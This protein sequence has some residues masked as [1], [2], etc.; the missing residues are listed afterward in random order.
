[1]KICKIIAILG[2]FLFLANCG[3]EDEKQFHLISGSENKNLEPIVT[4][5]CDAH[6]WAC[7]FSYKGSVDIRLGLSDS[8]FPY[9]AVWPAHSMW[10][11]LGDHSRRVRHAKSIFTSPVVFGLRKTVAEEL[12]LDA[13][14][15]VPITQL[16]SLV[17]EQK[18]KFVMTSATQ[19]NSGFVGLVGFA[20]ALQNN[21]K[22][23]SLETLDQG[24]IREDIRS[25]LQGVTRSSGSSGWLKEMFVQAAQDKTPFDAMVNYEA[26][27][28]EANQTL[29]ASGLEPMVILYLADGTGF[30]DS[31]LGFVK[32]DLD[33]QE[34]REAFFLGLQN[35]LLAEETQKTLLHLGRRTGFGSVIPNPPSD[36]FRED[37]GAV[38]SRPLPAIRFPT[39]A[40]VDRL[41]S[42]YQMDLRKPTLLGM[43]LDFSGSM[44]GAGHAQLVGAAETIFD[45]QNAAKLLIQPHPDD[46]YVL[47]PFSSF[48]HEPA[49]YKPGS[50]IESHAGDFNTV[51]DYLRAI[52]PEGGTDIYSCVADMMALLQ[53]TEA[54]QK[55]SHLVGIMLQSDGVSDG[56]LETIDMAKNRLGISIPV[57]ALLFGD[58]EK[59]QMALISETTGGRLFDGRQQLGAA[60]RK[61]RGYQ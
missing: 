42:D 49:F 46:L 3:G 8:H 10:I 20:T 13:G 33:D 34:E 2:V 59:G 23:L 16:I 5:Y 55:N 18:L 47:M 38:V 1:M 45:P 53:Q 27:I 29:E 11:E 52:T 6:G 60:F 61:A 15:L 19:S 51:A 43:C 37:W 30:A 28:L 22:P 14:A 26:L 35:H 32:R 17:S 7:H 50:V 21:Q 41:L 39:A 36:V 57:H 40:V 56:G 25:L 44:E 24:A 4:E 31:P 9:D 12:G 48:S 54:F 58:A